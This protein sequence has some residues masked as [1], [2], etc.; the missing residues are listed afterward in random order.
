MR[1]G[2]PPLRLTNIGI[3][4]GRA[5]LLAPGRDIPGLAP[6]GGYQRLSGTSAAAPF[7]TATAALL[8]SLRPALTAAQVRAALLRPGVARR[9]VIPPLLD[10]ASSQRALAAVGPRHARHP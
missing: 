5:G 1:R 2:R 3:G 8:W 10:A 9:S 7:V 4:I 6:E